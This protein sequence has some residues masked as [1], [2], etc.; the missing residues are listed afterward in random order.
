MHHHALLWDGWAYI[1]VGLA[2]AV[3]ALLI[4]R[5]RRNGGSIEL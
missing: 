2:I 3:I 5:H 1:G 4:W